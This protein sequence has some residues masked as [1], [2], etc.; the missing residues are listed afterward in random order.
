MSIVE[1]GRQSWRTR[2]FRVR[3]ET[4]SSHQH[5][6][7]RYHWQLLD[8]SSKDGWGSD[9]DGS[10]GSG[11]QSNTENVLGDDFD[12]RGGQFDTYWGGVDASRPPSQ[13]RLHQD[14]DWVDDDG[15]DPLYYHPDHLDHGQQSYS[16]FPP[17]LYSL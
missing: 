13:S 6:Q 5:A 15:N 11:W 4:E 17:I 16:H 14:T 12:M 9:M 3:K 7:L 2:D 8:L 1:T 10:S